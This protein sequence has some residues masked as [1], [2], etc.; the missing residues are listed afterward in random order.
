MALM[1]PRLAR[2]F[3]CNGYFPTDEST[4]ERALT[5]LAP[6]SGSMRIFDPC[7]GE[8]VALAEAAHVLGREQVEACAVEYDSERAEHARML[9]DRT[10]HSDLMDT[11]ISRQAFSLLW[12]NPPYGDLV[13]DPSGGFQYE[14]KGRKRLEKLFYQRTLPLLQYGGVMVLIVPHY[15][16]DDEFTSWISSHLSSV[17]VFAAA[18][19]TFKQVVIFGIRVRRQDLAL[20][21]DAVKACRDQLR[22]IG[23]KLEQPPLLPEQWQD[24]PYTVPPA[25]K[26][27]EHFYRMTLEPEQFALEVQRLGGLWPEFNLHFGQVGQSPRP[28]VRELSEWHLALALAAGAISGVVRSKTGQTLIL[29]GN[30]YKDKV[31]KTEFTEDEDGHVT[32]VRTLTDRFV[33]IIRAWDMTPESPTHGCILTISSHTARNADEEG[34]QTEENPEIRPKLFNPGHITVTQGVDHWIQCGFNPKPYLERHLAGDWGDLEDEDKHTNQR[35]LHNGDR[36]FSSYNL[37]D[38][39]TDGETRL[40]IIT[41]SDRSVTTLLFPSEY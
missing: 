34:T 13:P 10:L 41:E 32:E 24:L 19:P 28:P 2:N 37:N 7:A 14:G 18:D 23:Q 27:L 26:E 15:V 40:W 30:T 16:L 22:A 21:R 12:L 35:A 25:T 39:K 29:K 3:A 4:L 20:Q 38:E 6:S 17:R 33:P 31:S 36:L 5:A 1:F 11:M 8:G 9:L